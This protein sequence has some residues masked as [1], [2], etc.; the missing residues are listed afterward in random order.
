MDIQLSPEQEQL[1]RDVRAYMS[2]LMTPALIEEG[3]IPEYSEGGGPGHRKQLA[4][5]GA[6]GWIGV[7]WPK[8]WGGKAWTAMEQ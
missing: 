2:E 5:M 8:D 4:K 6:D 1:R 3:K 7:S